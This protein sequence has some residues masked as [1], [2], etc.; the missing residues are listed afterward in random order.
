MVGSDIG[1]DGDVVV[2]DAQA[3]EEHPASRRLDNAELDTRAS[4]DSACPGGSGVVALLNKGPVVQDPVGRAPRGMPPGH[5]ADVGQ[6]PGGRRLAVGAGD[7]DHG[8]ARGDNA[9]PRPGRC[10]ADGLGPGRDGVGER[11]SP[12]DVRQ[13]GTDGIAQGLCPA[14]MPPDEGDDDLIGG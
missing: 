7:G 10:R 9:R 11:H 6:H 12:G 1:D 4:E 3:L 14:A 2:G 5:H 13:R 8:D